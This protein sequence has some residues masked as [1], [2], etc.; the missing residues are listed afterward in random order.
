MQDPKTVI[1]VSENDLLYILTYIFHLEVSDLG[2]GYG[3]LQLLY[4]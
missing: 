1:A 4:K 3:L 2:R